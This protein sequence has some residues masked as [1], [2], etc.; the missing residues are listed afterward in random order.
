VSGKPRAGVGDTVEAM[1]IE[2]PAARYLCKEGTEVLIVID[3]CK[4]GG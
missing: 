2:A 1:G 3:Y 4:R